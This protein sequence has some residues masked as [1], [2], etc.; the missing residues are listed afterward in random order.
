MRSNRKPE[1]GKGGE[2]VQLEHEKERVRKVFSES[3]D[4]YGGVK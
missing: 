3:A 4:G 2:N 1:R